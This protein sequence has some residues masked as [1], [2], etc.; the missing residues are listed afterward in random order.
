MG[1][2]RAKRGQPPPPP[3]TE[4]IGE[5]KE[6]VVAKGFSN[7]GVYDALIAAD[8]TKHLFAELTADRDRPDVRPDEAYL[9][10]MT[11]IHPGWTF[12]LMQLYWPDPEPRREFYLNVKQQWRQ[13]T[14][15]MAIL[16]D[17]LLLA[18]DQMSIP[19]GRRTFVEFVYAGDESITWWETLPSICDRFGVKTFYLN[20]EEIR[21][22]AQWIFNPALE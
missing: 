5:T 2:F 11:S 1:L 20:R 19:F 4:E 22:L 7:I 3:H 21:N 14:Q 18:L 8:E 6:F 17:G 15:G 9:A 13:T 10:I 16:R 12:R